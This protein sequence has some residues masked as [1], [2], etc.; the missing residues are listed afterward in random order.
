MDVLDHEMELIQPIFSSLD[1]GCKIGVK[2]RPAHSLFTRL[3]QITDPAGNAR[4]HKSHPPPAGLVL[5]LKVYF[6]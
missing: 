5:R 3:H 6:I 2:G 4:R 1:V